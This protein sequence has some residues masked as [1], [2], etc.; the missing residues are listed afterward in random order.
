MSDALSDVR[1]GALRAVLLRQHRDVYVQARYN[2][3]VT[4]NVLR[5]ALRTVDALIAE[6][7]RLERENAA[8]RAVATAR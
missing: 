2:Y 7:A 8:L 6:R 5:N 1:V 3:G 4:D